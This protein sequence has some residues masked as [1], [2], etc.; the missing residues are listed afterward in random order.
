[1]SIFVTVIALVLVILY[2]ALLSG[3]GMTVL[4]NYFDIPS[5]LILLLLVIPVL[6]SA[7]M[8]RDFRASFRRAFSAQITCTRVELQRSMEAVKLARKSNWTAGIFS[9]LLGF[10]YVCKCYD[11]KDTYVFWVNMAVAVITIMYAA[12]FDL[13]Y[14]AVY[15][16]LKKRYMDFMQMG[17]EMPEKEPERTAADPGTY[18]VA[19]VK[20]GAVIPDT[21]GAAEAGQGPD[22]KQEQSQGSGV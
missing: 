18:E 5:L 10:V 4:P 15:G 9:F 16:R 8:F 21:Y 3:D 6:I 22:G 1:M 12:V 7:G 14:L 13:I 17:Y 11:E 20:Q 19:K 2:T